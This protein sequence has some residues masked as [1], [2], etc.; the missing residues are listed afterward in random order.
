MTSA[1]ALAQR[2]GPE[3]VLGDG[4]A[5]DSVD[6]PVVLLRRSIHLVSQKGRRK[7]QGGPV[8]AVAG[9]ASL[10]ACTAL[11]T[12]ST[13]ASILSLRRRMH[14]S[15]H[16]V[17]GC[18]HLVTPLTDASILSLRRRMR[19]SCY[20]VDGCVHLVT[21][22]TDASILLLHRYIHRFPVLLSTGEG[23]LTP[24]AGVAGGVLGGRQGGP[25]DAN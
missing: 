11:V 4:G 17:D 19:P 20:S 25:V 1:P 5:C 12:P 8:N 15:C 21:P 24:R 18:I 10:A 3:E 14:P 16:S 9:L 7:V 2:P 23:A 22:S 13:D 6:R